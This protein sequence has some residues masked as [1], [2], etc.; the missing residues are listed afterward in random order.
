MASLRAS[1]LCKRASLGPLA[2]SSAASEEED[3]D[4]PKYNYRELYDLAHRRFLYDEAN[5]VAL[6]PDEFRQWPI[7][8]GPVELSTAQP[9]PP[10]DEP[11]TYHKRLSTKYR[12]LNEHGYVK[13]HEY[14]PGLTPGSLDRQHSKAT[15][16]VLRTEIANSVNAHFRHGGEMK[17][18]ALEVLAA[19][20]YFLPVVSDF[21][22]EHGRASHVWTKSEDGRV[23]LNTFLDLLPSLCDVAMRQLAADEVLLELESPTYVLGDLHGNYRDLQYFASQFWRTGVDICP[24]NLL[25]L[26][27]YVDRGPHSVELI[28]Y[29]LALKV[30]YPSKVYLLR[31]NHELESVCGNIEYYGAGSFRHQLHSLLVAAGRGD[32]LESTW[33]AF[34]N[35]FNW[36]PLAATI[37]RTV[38][39]CHAG[40]PRAIMTQAPTS[41]A[42]NI[43]ERIKAMQRPLCEDD[44]IDGA[45]DCMAMDML[46]SDPASGR[47]LPFMGHQG[48]P[49]GFAPNMDRGGDSCVFGEAAVKAFMKQ[50][51]CDFM[52]RAHQPPDKGIRYQTG[53][54]VVTVFSSSRYCG[55]SNS[56][57]LIVISKSSM[58]I[59]TTGPTD[60][61]TER[62]GSPSKQQMRQGVTANAGNAMDSQADQQQQ[63]QQQSQ[64]QTPQRAPRGTLL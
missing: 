47:D 52:L 19:L 59:V 42:Q 10:S 24:S 14:L 21:E 54:R 45:P 44:D 39:C 31:G 55:L 37:D 22:Y 6:L 4:M 16:L 50:T 3:D 12:Q 7:T 11:G 13:A 56:A 43:L 60:E 58:D 28:A 63:Q 61:V 8:L 17:V 32:Q 36:L 35:C 48:L 20:E 23:W 30:L 38:F 29:L 9:P 53:A 62:P 40:I 18:T 46:W 41:P 5:N 34:M 57:A 51:G 27:D 2:D 33:G 49:A 15:S 26:G 25:F 64:T 1:P